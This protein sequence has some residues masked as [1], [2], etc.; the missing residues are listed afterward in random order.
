VLL[1]DREDQL[2]SDRVFDPY[3]AVAEAACEAWRKLL[4]QPAT[5]TS[6]SLGD[7]AYIGQT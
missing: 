4:A 6:I 7:R 1:G 5:I 3:D 2:V